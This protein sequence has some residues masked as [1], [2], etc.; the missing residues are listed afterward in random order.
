MTCERQGRDRAIGV[1]FACRVISIFCPF[2]AFGKGFFV[3]LFL[4]AAFSSS[5]RGAVAGAGYTGEA[6]PPPLR[7]HVYHIFIQNAVIWQQSRSLVT[8]PGHLLGIKFSLWNSAPWRNVVHNSFPFCGRP[9][10]GRASGRTLAGS[11]PPFCGCALDLWGQAFFVCGSKS[12]VGA[13]FSA[14]AH[15]IFL[16]LRGKGLS[17]V[18]ISEVRISFLPQ[19][20][21][22]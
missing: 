9:L 15:A 12:S 4:I 21:S 19:K 3:L 5:E 22:F 20:F 8:A 10:C 14:C 11:I 18:K 7:V 16:P 6:G 17:D 13:Y 1:L 2:P